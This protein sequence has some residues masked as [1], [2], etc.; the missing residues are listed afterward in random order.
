MLSLR[1]LVI[2]LHPIPSSSG[3]TGS[4]SWSSSVLAPVSSEPIKKIFLDSGLGRTTEKQLRLSGS[5]ALLGA[6][7]VLSLGNYLV[8]TGGL[9]AAE[10]CCLAAI[11]SPLLWMQFF[12]I[13]CLQLHFLLW[14]QH[15]LG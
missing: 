5:K 7:A 13:S 6:A 9:S 8:W 1:V 3:E 4:W 11:D 2:P 12:A 10:P 14:L 15:F